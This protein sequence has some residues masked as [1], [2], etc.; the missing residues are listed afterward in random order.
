MQSLSIT[1]T[2][3]A[4]PVVRFQNIPRINIANTPG[5]DKSPCTSG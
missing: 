1:P 2:T 5:L 3:A 4:V